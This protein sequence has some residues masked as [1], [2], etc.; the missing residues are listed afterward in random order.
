VL[1]V[2]NVPVKNLRG[3]AEAVQ[4]CTEKYLRFDLEYN[5]V[6]IHAGPVGQHADEKHPVGLQVE[7]T[8]A[9]WCLRTC[10]DVHRVLKYLTSLPL[11]DT[12]NPESSK[13]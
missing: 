2:N 10:L 12:L 9:C 11:P 13:P 8:S 5:Q 6:R 1:R 3:L 4:G 7:T